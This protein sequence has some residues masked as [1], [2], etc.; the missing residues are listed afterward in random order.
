MKKILIVTLILF[1]GGQGFCQDWTDDQLGLADT[2][3]DIDQLS[4]IEKDAIMYINLARLFPSEFVKI[5]LESYSGPEGNE[6][7]LNNSAY[8]RSLI[9]TLRNSKPVDALDFDESLYQSARC[10]AKEQGIK[11]TVGHKRR[12][13]TPNYSAECCSYGMV[14]GEDI[15]MQW[16]IDDRVQNLGHRI[17]CLNRSYKKI[18]LST[19]THKKYGTC[20]VADLGR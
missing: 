6:N 3:R 5:E 14:N 10:F 2:G 12:N 7:S 4:E 20:A 15:A 11:G 1:F 8:K 16:L 13:C 18:G 17:N 9:T 19:H